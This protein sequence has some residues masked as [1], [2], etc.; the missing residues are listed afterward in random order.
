M[1]Y[2]YMCM[3]IIYTHIEFEIDKFTRDLKIG[4]YSHA[5]QWIW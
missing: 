1:Q 2:K 4:H 5:S 3:H